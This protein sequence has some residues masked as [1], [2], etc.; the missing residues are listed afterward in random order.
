M[1]GPQVILTGMEAAQLA[2]FHPFIVTQE[3]LFALPSLLGDLRIILFLK[4]DL[5]LKF[6]LLSPDDESGKEA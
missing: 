4:R 1:D 6:Q 5:H 2:I 3:K